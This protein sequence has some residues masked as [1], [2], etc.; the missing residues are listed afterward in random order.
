VVDEG[1]YWE[2]KDPEQLSSLL[3]DCD[4]ALAKLQRENPNARLRVRLESGR[5][6]DAL[7]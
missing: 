3:R 1:E 4:D 7:E 5:I 6:I 2:S